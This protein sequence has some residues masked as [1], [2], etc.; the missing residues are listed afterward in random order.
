MARRV[1]AR[2]FTYGDGIWLGKGESEGDTHLMAHELTHVVQQGGA[3]PASA[4]IQRARLPCVSSRVIDIYSVNVGNTMRTAHDD[5]AHANS[6]LCQCG[7]EL[8]VVGGSSIATNALDLDPPLGILNRS[9]GTPHRELEELLTHRPGGN[10]IHAYYV[11]DLDGGLR[12]EAVGS[13]R[14]SPSL[15]DS[16][17]VSEASAVADTFVHE[18]GHVLI[19]S[20]AHHALADNLMAAGTI[21]N[22][23][24]NE[25]EQTQCNSM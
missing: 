9:T 3:S 1:G 5:L 18:L 24:V 12:G 14:F 21:R 13:T 2:A 25:L 23:G 7:I 19:N 10:V 6:I 15:P 8:N 22:I 4:H 17:I 11:P 16:V 20:G